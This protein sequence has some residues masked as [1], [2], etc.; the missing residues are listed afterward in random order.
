MR[1]YPDLTVDEEYFKLGEL[2]HTGSLNDRQKK[3]L[4][5]MGFTGSISDGFLQFRNG[6]SF[7]PYLLNGEVFLDWRDTSTLFQNAGGTTPA[8]PSGDPVRLGLDKSQGLTLGPEITPTTQSGASWD[9]ATRT[10]TFAEGTYSQFT[11]A[12]DVGDVLRVRGSLDSIGSSQSSTE[13]SDNTATFPMVYVGGVGQ[14]DE[15]IRII[16]EA[17][18]KL[19]QASNYGATISNM[20]VQK[21]SGSHVTAPS[22]A[23]RPTYKADKTLNDDGV[24]DA[25]ILPLTG[26]YSAYIAAGSS[27]ISDES[28]V[29]ADDYDILRDDMIGAVVVS[30]TLTASQKQQ[31]ATYFGVTV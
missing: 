7:N 31:V 20:R 30:G 16:N 5:A 25:L 14:I 28:V 10:A 4:G 2:G 27:L 18:L 3:A 24:D 8:A 29:M 6:G 9:S 21:I 26:T 19:F 22:D 23:A 11:F 17:S 13:F 15:T 1:L 12:A